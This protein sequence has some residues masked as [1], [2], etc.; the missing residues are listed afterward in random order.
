M[1]SIKSA[2]FVLLA[3]CISLASAGEIKP[4]TQAQFDALTAQGKPVLIFVHADWCPTCRAQKP[5]IDDLMK[6][7]GFSNVT[8]L[9]INFDVD[10]N[11]LKKY[12]VSQQ[13]TLIAFKAGKEVGRTI[14]DTTRNGIETLIKKSVN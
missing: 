10:Q 3:L 1:K 11:L 8:T 4:Y 2:L 6:Q 9:V 7:P 5:I 13:S 14:G 12:H